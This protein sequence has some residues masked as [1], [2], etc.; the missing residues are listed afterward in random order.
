MDPFAWTKET[1][2][3]SVS[4]RCWGYTPYDEG[5]DR[6]KLSTDNELREIVAMERELGFA[7]TSPSS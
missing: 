1:Y 7:L 3:A 4:S 5:W 6:G 2:E